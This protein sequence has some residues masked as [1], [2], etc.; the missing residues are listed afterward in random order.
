MGI[1]ADSLKDN[2]QLLKLY[3]GAKRKGIISE[4]TADLVNYFAAAE[5]ALHD[6]P[7][8]PGNLFAWIVMGKHWETIKDEA[9]DR[10]TDRIKVILGRKYVRS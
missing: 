9:E 8:T 4:S 5:Q 10:A 6:D 2:N 3:Q 1:S 7:E